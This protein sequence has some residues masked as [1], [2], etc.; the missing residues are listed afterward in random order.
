VGVSVL[1]LVFVL[2]FVLALS[3]FEGITN[4]GGLLLFV[5][6]FVLSGPDG[7]LF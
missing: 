6:V 7:W 4:G 2:L 1:V 3:G 5:S